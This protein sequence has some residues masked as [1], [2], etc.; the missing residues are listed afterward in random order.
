MAEF[1]DI[2]YCPF[3]GKE[4]AE[5]WNYCPY[6]SKA[7]PV[8]S[9][10]SSESTPQ[11]ALDP[12]MAMSEKGL[13]WLWEKIQ[14]SLRTRQSAEAE[15]LASSYLTEKSNSPDAQ[16]LMGAVYL[17]SRRLEEARQ[18]FELAVAGAPDSVFVRLRF[19]EYWLALGVTPRAQEEIEQAL[20]ASANNP[21]VYREVL[22]IANG[23]KA[24]T[25]GS[26]V[27]SP[28]KLRFGPF[29]P[30]AKKNNPRPGTRVQDS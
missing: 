28:V 4:R 25:G 27:R 3:C 22:A 18:M 9:G 26:Y 13:S 6:C 20:L 23:I 19:A 7:Y 8:S 29:R 30:R 10:V 17:H 16:A 21:H 5:N 24:K 15:K 11:T 14:I 1:I 12:G 2:K